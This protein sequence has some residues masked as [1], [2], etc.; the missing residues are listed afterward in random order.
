MDRETDKL[1]LDEYTQVKNIMVDA[2]Q[3]K[4]GMF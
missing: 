3:D 2:Y 1:A 4:L